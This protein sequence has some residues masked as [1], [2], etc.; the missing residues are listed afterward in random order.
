[1]FPSKFNESAVNSRSGSKYRKDIVD[2]I[3]QMP[4]P[5]TNIQF[6]APEMSFEDFEA[7]LKTPN[8]LIILEPG[9]YTSTWGTARRTVTGVSNIFIQKE[10][11]GDPAE[12]FLPP[13]FW[14]NP[15]N[16][17]ISGVTYKDV[18]G[19]KITNANNMV[20]EYCTFQGMT[21]G[22]GARIV[23]GI[24]C[25][26]Q[27]CLFLDGVQ[28]ST[29]NG[30]VAVEGQEGFPSENVVI[31]DC[32]FRNV[33]DA[34]GWTRNHNDARTDIPGAIFDNNEVYITE[35]YYTTN[36]A[37]PT[38]NLACAEDGVDLKE[39]SYDRT[40]PCI[41]SNNFFHGFRPTDQTCGGSGSAGTGIN[42][43]RNTQN[44][45]FENNIIA[46][47]AI[48]IDIQG[49]RE[50]EKVDSLEFRNN[51]I[52][53]IRFIPLD[54]DRP[55]EDNPTGKSLHVGKGPTKIKFIGNIFSSGEIDIDPRSTSEVRM[56]NNKL[57]LQNTTVGIPTSRLSKPESLIFYN[58]EY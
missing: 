34:I 55:I 22:K 21:D 38:T 53:D 5:F 24:D 18:A 2:F 41:V 46:D 42:I 29:D 31:C 7:L 56:R 20:F 17:W 9:D 36:P 10:V 14:K 40:R 39:G 58:L 27:S 50:D 52:A 15:T 8:T 47:S 13:F 12:A 43:H 49:N 33:G 37:D 25:N 19:H 16:I 4:E 26:F 44:V 30:G 54:T 51:L 23:G 35:E 45:R 28:S 32:E 3:A 57:G 6:A 11:T 48:G 1:M